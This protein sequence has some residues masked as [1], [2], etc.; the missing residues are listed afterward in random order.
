MEACL[1]PHWQVWAQ[2]GAEEWVV[3]VLRYGYRIPFSSNPPLSPVPIHLPS[4]SP[5]S[6]RGK[7]LAVEIE[8]LWKKGALERAPSSP[9]FYSRVFVATKGSGAWRPI[10]ICRVSTGL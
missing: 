7:A 6:I 1:A 4:Y 2:M 9:G 3:E 8:A 10:S 5:T